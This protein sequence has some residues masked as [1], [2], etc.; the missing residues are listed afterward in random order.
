MLAVCATISTLTPL[1]AI[2]LARFGWIGLLPVIVL[3]GAIL[4]GRGVGFSSALLELAPA[5]ERPTYSALNIVLILPVAFLP[6]IAGG[7]LQ[8]WSYPTL[9]LVAALFIGM[10]ALLTQRLPEKVPQMVKVHDKREG[11]K[12]G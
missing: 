2:V 12:S 1:L 10:G 11:E 5:A 9:F 8:H 3:G 4:N 6:L 7:L